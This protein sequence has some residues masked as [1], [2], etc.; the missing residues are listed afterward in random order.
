MIGM[1]V[2]NGFSNEE[3]TYSPELVKKAESGDTDAQNKLGFCYSAGE[4][5][6]KDEE[7]A[8][9]WYTRAAQQGYAKAQY[10]LGLCYFSGNG[11]AREPYEA[12]KLWKMS[13]EQ[14]FAE[15]QYR[16]GHFH[17]SGIELCVN[18]KD[19]WKYATKTG[20]KGK[21]NVKS[22]FCDVPTRGGELP[23]TTFP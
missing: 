13:A 16:L 14:G 22:P 9:R 12:V 8:V 10:N 3:V 17:K 7:E 15:A 5:V 18:D 4:G 11:V 1:L 19:Y 2:E 6:P 21:I 20:E 23:P